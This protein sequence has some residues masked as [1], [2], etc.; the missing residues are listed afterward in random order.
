[1]ARIALIIAVS[2]L[3]GALPSMALA[4]E[5]VATPRTAPVALWRFLN[6][7][8]SPQEV[9]S[10]LSTN[11]VRGRIQRDRTTRREIVDV[12]D[13]VSVAGHRASL[14]V[15]FVADGLFWVDISFTSDTAQPTEE[16]DTLFAALSD[17]YGAPENIAP[18]QRYREEPE[19][20]T[21]TLRGTK[22]SATF[23]RDELQVDATVISG[24]RIP[25]L[26]QPTGP[27]GSVVKQML[28]REPY[29][30]QAQIRYWSLNDA[31]RY[32]AQEAA[33][34]AQE[35][36]QRVGQARDGL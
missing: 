6:A 32:G 25:P 17:L 3:A 1:M 19:R 22:V 20:S 21:E 23:L 7:G 28:E 29:R 26:E 35:K 2:I 4:Q 11:G 14:D 15:A 13:P 24:V 34:A 27:A 9:V 33:N 5:P 12:R 8:M 10:V 30:V 18:A 36:Q 16:A 31:N